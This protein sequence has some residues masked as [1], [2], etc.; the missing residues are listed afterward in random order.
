[1]YDSAASPARPRAVASKAV[2]PAYRPQARS[3][4]ASTAT[5][6]L[7]TRSLPLQS[8]DGGTCAARCTLDTFTRIKSAEVVMREHDNIDPQAKA[9]LKRA[10]TVVDLLGYG[11]GSTVGAGIYSLVGAGA[12]VAG[13]P[14][15]AACRSGGADAECGRTG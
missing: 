14:H 13:T 15:L 9:T 11:I 12:K 1:M 8:R 5:S 7:I 6:P 3:I 10:L 4:D 2:R